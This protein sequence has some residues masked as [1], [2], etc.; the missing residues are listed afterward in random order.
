[1]PLQSSLSARDLG[2]VLGCYDDVYNLKVGPGWR[3]TFTYE[4][5]GMPGV[6][7][8]AEEGSGSYPV[9]AVSRTEGIREHYWIDFSYDTQHAKPAEAYITPPKTKYDYRWATS[10][11]LGEGR[12]V[13][14]RWTDDI[15][16]T[17][18]PSDLRFKARVV[19]E[20]K[21]R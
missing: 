9:M 2:R 14:R 15:Q 20:I 17:G 3:I 11:R 7:L 8:W 1:M 10:G 16:S 13:V 19:M 6:H 18:D 12:W 21:P 5:Q 4:E